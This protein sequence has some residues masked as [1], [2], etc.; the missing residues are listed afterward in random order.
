ME[1]LT[2]MPAMFSECLACNLTRGQ[3]L[4]LKFF[5]C[6]LIVA[7]FLS[8]KNNHC[9]ARNFFRCTCVFALAKTGKLGINSSWAATQ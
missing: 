6:E 7:T 4:T 3:H 8:K 9:A 1:V 5:R 2:Q